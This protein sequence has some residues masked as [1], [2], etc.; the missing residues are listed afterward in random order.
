MTIQKREKIA[1]FNLTRNTNTLSSFFINSTISTK[2]I[3]KKKKAPPNKKDMETAT[4]RCLW[5]LHAASNMKNR[6]ETRRPSNNEHKNCGVDV[7]STPENVR[8]RF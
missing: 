5:Q 4:R 3:D 8:A 1:T 6:C 7:L 2:I